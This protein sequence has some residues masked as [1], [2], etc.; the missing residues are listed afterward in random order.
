[1]EKRNRKGEGT[2]FSIYTDSISPVITGFGKRCNQ[3]DIKIDWETSL[4]AKLATKDVSQSI[5]K[6]IDFTTFWN[7]EY[8]DKTDM[9][10]YVMGFISEEIKILTPP[11]PAPDC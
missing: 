1:M 11:A 6:N 10:T 2:I 9:I 5:F 8:E 4:V 3:V 7:F